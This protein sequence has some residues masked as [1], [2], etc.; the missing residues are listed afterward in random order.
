MTRPDSLLGRLASRVGVSPV[1]LLVGALSMV[2]ALGAIT[3][4]TVANAS[5]GGSTVPPPTGT[6]STANQ[7]PATPAVPPALLTGSPRPASPS[8]A[9]P[10]PS[11][12][13]ALA[14]LPSSAPAPQGITVEALPADPTAT[15]AQILQAKPSASSLATPQFVWA[16]AAARTST[17]EPAGEFG[18]DAGAGV[19]SDASATWTV[20]FGDGSAPVTVA[21]AAQRCPA[22]SAPFNGIDTNA[23][24]PDHRYQDPGDYTVTVS[25][26]LIGCDGS[27]GPAATTSFSYEWISD[28]GVPVEPGQI[29]NSA[30]PPSWAP[31]PNLQATTGTV[32]EPPTPGH[33]NGAAVPIYAYCE[34]PTQAA[35]GSKFTIS[36]SADT[37]DMATPVYFFCADV[38]CSFATT[39]VTPVSGTPYGPPGGTA[40]VNL[41]E[42]MPMDHTA[43][44]WSFTIAQGTNVFTENVGVLNG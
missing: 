22:G 13:T 23:G 17:T 41:T 30:P 4:V 8:R 42:T 19:Q 44:Q 27:T 18:V 43:V 20:D 28:G 1:V 29:Q 9:V 5:S 37:A 34:G 3:V 7:S 24:M 40:T 6:V 35:A 36:C 11:L 15:V 26:R 33:P 31:P 21:V 16:Q 12:K 10:I 32:L 38:G 2:L 39:P 25:I 14:P